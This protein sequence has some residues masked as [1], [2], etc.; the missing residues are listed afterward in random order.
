ME[1]YFLAK[2]LHILGAAV[3]L[4][5]GLG[6]AFFMFMADWRR[7]VAG[8]AATARIVVIA[9]FLFTAPAVALQF[10]TGLWLARLAGHDPLGDGWLIASIVI[11][12]LVGLCWLPVVFLQIRM[13]DLSAAAL[14]D[15][16]ALPPAY[17][18]YMRIW[19][20]LGWPA[21]LGVLIIVGLMIVRPD[22]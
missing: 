5:T 1:L 4:G 9:D 3:L 16:T 22:F 21:F 13:R 2:F 7:D 10:A 11:F 12:V 14:R 17:R 15:G 6:I 19:F 20:A 8:I 18:K